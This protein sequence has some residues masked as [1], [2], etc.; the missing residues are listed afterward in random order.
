M[1]R[2]RATINKDTEIYQL[3]ITLDRIR[4]PIW[5]RVLVPANITLGELHLVI[6]RSMG[7]H[8]YHLH[9][10]LIGRMTIEGPEDR[11]SSEDTEEDRIRLQDIAPAAGMKFKYEYD[12]GDDWQHTILVEKQ[13]PRAEGTKY[14]VCTAG[15]R[16]CPPEDCG[17][18]WGYGE[19]LETLAD[20]ESGDHNE[21]MD[22]AGGEIDPE[23]FSVE[24]VNA[25][26]RF[27]DL[28]SVV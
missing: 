13:L 10:F 18:S 14:P 23:Q 12:F 15:R 16:A 22:W 1:A 2:Q 25:R 24:E 7:W 21:M 19:L 4:P 26:L 3:K 17:G 6:Q 8:N 27:L 5:R 9:A 11:M 28:K 20:P